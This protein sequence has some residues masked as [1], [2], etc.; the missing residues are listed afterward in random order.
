[1]VGGSFSIILKLFLPWKQVLNK[2]DWLLLLANT[3]DHFDR[4]LYSLMVPIVGPL[5]F[6]KTDHITSMIAAY[7]LLATGIVTGPLGSWLFGSLVRTRPP[8]LVLYYSLLGVGISSF[9]MGL[10]P[11]YDDI[12]WWAAL[13]LIALR[14]SMEIFATGEATIARIL[15]MEGKP[16]GKAL[17]AASS[18]ETTKI[19]GVMIASF[20][21]TLIAASSNPSVFWRVPFLLGGIVSLVGWWARRRWRKD[22]K[23]NSL[24][25]KDENLLSSWRLCWIQRKTLLRIAIIS[26]AGYL[27]YI[28]PFFWLNAFV[29]LVT[30]IS[31]AQMMAVST[32]LMVLDMVLV[33][34][35]GTLMHNLDVMRSLK[36][37]LGALIIIV[38]PGFW[39]LPGAS[40]ISVMALRLCLI[41][42]GVALIGP[43]YGWYQILRKKWGKGSNTSSDDYL[44][45][46]LGSSFGNGSIG[47]TAP[48]ICLWLWHSTGSTL[49]PALYLAAWWLIA[50]LLA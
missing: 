44:L 4:A 21:V 31:F 6:P 36:I 46:G 50:V 42:L 5:F 19:M 18:Y 38:I 33:P 15:I 1:M 17:L 39:I 22:I 10:L 47:R 48:A 40:W 35:L 26:S 34:L 29:P 3:L 28:V 8:T 41:V 12:G 7:S 37:C 14:V 49:A 30:E 23:N 27:T 13:I 45:I 11:V 2:R 16:D 20:A 43:I 9:A 32:S 24:I 25:A